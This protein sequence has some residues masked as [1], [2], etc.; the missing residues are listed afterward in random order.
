MFTNY[1]RHFFWVILLFSCI[2]NA[3][4]LTGSVFD[5]KTKEPLYGVSV[6]FDGTTNGTATDTQG[7]FVIS[8]KASTESALVISYLG[9]DSK[10]F[11][12]RKLTNG[13]KIYLKP[14]EEAL[15]VV[16]LEN[17]PWSRKKKMAIFRRE[18]IGNTAGASQ[19][20]ILN[21]DDIDVVY[22]PT[23]KTLSAYASKPIEIRNK[24][25]GYTISYNMEEF[26]AKLHITPSGFA[27]TNSVYVE[28]TSFYSELRKKTRRR[29]VKARE[30]EFEQSILNFMRSLASEKLKENKFELFHR[31]FIISPDKYLDVVKEDNKITKIEMKLSKLIILYNRPKYGLE[32]QSSIEILDENKVFYI[33]EFGNFSPP[34][35]LT[36]GGFFGKK[37][38][39]NTLPLDYNL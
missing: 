27:L 5:E 29:N 11:D 9:Y 31:G 21:E 26:E 36:F 32:Y 30:K 18:F 24:Y 16:Y 35:K 33:N 6:Y 14:K 28:G 4:T 12:V 34:K 7:K 15:G 22:N 23:T 2:S 1:T 3:Q 38:I 20:K 19:C 17:D 39:A 13:V 37:R 10:A 8:Y 25:L